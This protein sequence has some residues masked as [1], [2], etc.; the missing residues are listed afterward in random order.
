MFK[1]F[2][3]LSSGFRKTSFEFKLF[4]DNFEFF[5]GSFTEF[6]E[7]SKFLLLLSHGSRIV[8]MVIVMINIVLFFLINISGEK[9]NFPDCESILLRN[10]KSSGWAWDNVFSPE[11]ILNKEIINNKNWNNEN[12][13]RN[14]FGVNEIRS[15]Y[16]WFNKNVNE[17]LDIIVTLFLSSLRQ[18]SF[19]FIVSVEFGS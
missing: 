7:R 3:F 17:V 9:V 4:A 6:L 16:V 18:L 5:S 8:I 11:L 15:F 2:S 13:G 14:E 12:N 10:S 1:R 19:S